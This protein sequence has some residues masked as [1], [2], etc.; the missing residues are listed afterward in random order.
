MCG[1]VYIVHL[2]EKQRLFEFITAKI[3]NEKNGVHKTELN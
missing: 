3:N 2:R 1:A